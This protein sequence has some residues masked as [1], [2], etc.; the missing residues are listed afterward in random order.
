[1][2]TL[3]DEVG[4][5]QT[6]ERVHK[7]FYDKVYAHPWLKL[8]FFGHSQESIEHR[9]TTFMA[10]K[11]GGAV[12]YWGKNPKMAHRA[13]YI[14]EELFAIRENLLRQALVEYGLSNELIER[15]LRI[16]SAFK[17]MIV[18]DSIETFY[19]TTWKHEKR[20]IFPRPKNYRD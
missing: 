10:Q 1:M 13:M 19:K 5:M 12:E 6:L 18:K 11:M 2:T 15:W 3:Y 20:K 17:K 8:F 9:Q 7:M 14:T 16:D 4:G